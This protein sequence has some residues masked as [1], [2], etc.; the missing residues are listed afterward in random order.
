MLN[1][2]I[3]TPTF[4]PCLM[5][6]HRFYKMLPIRFTPIITQKRPVSATSTGIEHCFIQPS[7]M[8]KL[9]TILFI[10]YISGGLTTEPTT[11]NANEIQPLFYIVA[12][13]LKK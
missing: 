5:H 1:P 4:I 8:P 2:A 11:I 12:A 3:R 7:H 13:F 6:N 10:S 9:L